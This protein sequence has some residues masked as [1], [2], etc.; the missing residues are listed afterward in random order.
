M[1]RRPNEIHLAGV[2]D[3]KRNIMIDKLSR[4]NF[5]NRSICSVP[6]LPLAM[7]WLSSCNSKTE[8]KKKEEKAAP[9]SSDPCND[10][11]GVTEAD[12][13]SRQKMGYVK[14]SPIPESKCQNCQLFL[15]F[16]ET[17]GCGNC[18]LFKGPVLTTAYCTYWAPQVAG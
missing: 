16:K 15:P 6:I 7:I 14:I 17:P 4:R 8:T 18:Q 13:K 3:I 10:F 1:K 9:K 11:T 5:I 2:V 12:L